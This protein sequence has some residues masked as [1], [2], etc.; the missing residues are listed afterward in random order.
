MNE[1]ERR[2]TY[3]QQRARRGQAPTTAER[4]AVRRSVRAERQS[5]AE[6]DAERRLPRQSV[7]TARR[8]P[9]VLVVAA[10]V[11]LAGVLFL[12]QTCAQAAPINVTVNGSQYTLRGDKTM[13]VAI[14]ESGLPINPGD[15]ISLRGTVLERHAGEPFYATV[16]GTETIDPDLRLNDGDTVNVED[17]HD[18]VED[19][20][21][22]EEALP[23]EVSIRGAGPIHTFTPGSDGVLETRTGRISGDVVEKITLEPTALTEQRSAAKVGSDKVIALTFESGP[24]TEYTSDIL[25]VLAAN[26]A[27][28]TFFCVGTQIEHDGADLVRRAAEEGH[29]IANGTY[30]AARAGGGDM[31]QLTPEEQ[32]Q[33]VSLGFQAIESALGSAPSKVLRVPGDIAGMTD[34]TVMNVS[35]QIDAE[36][37]WTLDTGDWVYTPE[38]DIYDVLVSAQPGDVIRMHDGGDAQGDTIAALKRA[39][40]ELKKKGYSFVTI[41]ELMAY[42]PD[43]L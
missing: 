6:A 15:L 28:A 31:A 10:L 22:V 33:E 38:D 14:K 41:D 7:D 39:L 1:R 19:Y 43:E 32:A 5:R 16:N 24:S 17:G 26:D 27:K 2:P 3:E 8:P 11:V 36:I 4:A 29:Q 34:W 23:Y 30:S 20:D 25:D 40:P 13:Q 12:L 35:D 37:T 21:A 18:S 9:L 42:A